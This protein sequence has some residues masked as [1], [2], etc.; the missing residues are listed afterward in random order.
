MIAPS[1]DWFTGASSVNLAEEGAWVKSRTV[2]LPAYDSGGDDGTTYK[3]ADRNTN[4][5]KPVS[6]SSN[7][8]FVVNGKVK[9]VA[10]LVLTRVSP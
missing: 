9:P 5:K 6:R 8:H 4:P 7:R 2:V 3:A 10:T 1:P